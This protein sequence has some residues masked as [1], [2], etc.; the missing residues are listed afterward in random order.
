[1]RVLYIIIY[2]CAYGI[3]WLFG[4]YSAPDFEGIQNKRSACTN[5]CTPVRLESNHR[6]NQ[7]ESNS[8]KA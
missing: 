2:F 7:E 6:R 4:N 5:K 1:V 3:P 8:F